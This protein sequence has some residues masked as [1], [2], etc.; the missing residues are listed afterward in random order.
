MLERRQAQ[1]AT[2]EQLNASGEN[3]VSLTYPDARAMVTHARTSVGYNAQVTVDA[4]HKLIVEQHHYHW[5]P[6]VDLGGNTR[7]L[8]P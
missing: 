8:K 4:K 1:E 7:A 5:H 2:L 3:Q 6:A